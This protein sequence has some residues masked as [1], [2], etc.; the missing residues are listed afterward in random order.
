MIKFILQS[1]LGVVLIVIFVVVYMKVAEGQDWFKGALACTS[2]A[3]G[4]YMTSYTSFL[5]SAV[6][7]GM[8]SIFL[9][10][11]LVV[12]DGV[13]YLWRRW[14]GDLEEEEPLIV[15]EKEVESEGSG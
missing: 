3:M 10:V 11:G 9:G 14:R 15:M 4:T 8:T 5:G 13:H 2:K 1:A 6:V 7:M 12:L